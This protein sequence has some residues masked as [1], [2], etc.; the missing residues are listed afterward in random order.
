MPMII[1]RND[2][3]QTNAVEIRIRPEKELVGSAL[4]AIRSY[5][6]HFFKD[7]KDIDRI[8]LATEEAVGNVLSY[9]MTD[10]LD[11]ITVTADAADGELTVCVLDSGLPGDYEETL[12]GEE[13]LGIRLMHGAVD[14][15]QVENLG[16]AGRCQR[17]VKYYSSIPDLSGPSE[18]PETDVR[19]NSQITIRS[20]CPS[21]ILSICRAVYNE[22]GLTYSRD[23]VYYP[24][25]FSAAVAK[26][27]M[28]SFVAVDEE[29]RLAGHHAVFE[30]DTV[31]GI[32]EVGIG[33]V[34][35]NYRNM[36]IARR[37][38]ERSCSYV[39]DETEGRVLVGCCV[40]SHPYTQKNCLLYH[41]VPC[42]FLLNLTPPDVLQ[43][44]MKTG[45][46]FTSDAIAATVFDRAPETVYLPEKLKSTAEKIYSWMELPRTIVTGQEPAFGTDSTEC[47]WYFNTAKRNGTIVILSP[48]QD[49]KCSL[50]SSIVGLKRRGA[51]MI[52]LYFSAGQSGASAVYEAAREEGFFFTG[53]LPA[54]DLGDMILMQK[55][56][57]NVVDYDSLIT[58]DLFTE[59]L[60]DIRRFDPDQS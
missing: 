24:E 11:C 3:K 36:G 4:S 13:R 45:G 28:Q 26:G 9:S 40:M 5:A 22:Y 54:S 52:M 44:S 48:G 19:E 55:M 46:G 43:S 47:K 21:E 37:L 33:V 1:H 14:F 12:N 27:Q 29:G 51:E 60:A 23:I 16:K 20:A 15:V 7:R 39:R 50:H 25:R 38:M 56:M 49:H 2:L 8:V 31:P 53:L 30:W 32:R 18:L 57:N 59:L 17:L 58:C 41:L 6:G 35:R 10:H 34:D 42:G